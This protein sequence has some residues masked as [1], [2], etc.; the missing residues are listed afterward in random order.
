MMKERR[1]HE[2]PYQRLYR[3]PP[4]LRWRCCRI[5]VYVLP[6][7]DLDRRRPA[8]LNLFFVHLHV[9]HRGDELRGLPVRFRDVDRRGDSLSHHPGAG[10]SVVQSSVGMDHG[11]NRCGDPQQKHGATGDHDRTPR[12]THQQRYEQH[13][14]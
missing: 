5:Y 3:S 4:F 13:R 6:A 7:E 14:N 9:N 12:P 1:E 10:Q 2:Y 8:C 11:V